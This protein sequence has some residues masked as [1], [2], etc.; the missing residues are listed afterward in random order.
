M[1]RLR[2][3]I[4][5]ARLYRP[6]VLLRRIESSRSSSLSAPGS[7]SFD[8][9]ADSSSAPLGDKVDRQRVM[10]H[11]FSTGG[12]YGGAAVYMAEL[13]PDKR[14]GYWGSFLEMGTLTGTASAALVCASC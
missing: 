1:V 13:A 10:V 8:L 9:W 2:G 3:L 5:R 14:R 11:G 12:E 4:L 7:S 6:R